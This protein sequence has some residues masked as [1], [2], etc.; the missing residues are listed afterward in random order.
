MLAVPGLLA[1]AETVVA[2]V[3]QPLRVV[4]LVGVL[5]SVDLFS[6]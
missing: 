5:A 1:P 6:E 2:V 4:L 3:T